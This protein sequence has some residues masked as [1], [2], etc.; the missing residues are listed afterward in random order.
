M[1]GLFGVIRPDG[2]LPSD[3]VI[4]DGLGAQLLHRGPN[5]SGF[6]DEKKALLGM[7]RLSI[8]DPLHGWQPF[9]TEDRSVGVLGN[10]EIYNAGELRA[11]LRARGHVLHTNSDIE[12]VP[13]LFE[14]FGSD[15]FGRLRG[16]FALV[17]VDKASRE[18]LLVRDRLGEKPLCY[19]QSGGAIYISSEQRALVR[20]GVTPLE[21][22]ADLV[23]DYLLYGYSPEP[24]SLIR[25]VRKVPAGHTLKISLMDGSIEESAYWTP[26][27]DVG[28]M[29]VSTD[30]LASAIESAVQASCTSDVPVGLALSG[31][32]D[33][34]L[35]ASLAVRD[36]TDLR[37][38]TVGYTQQGT[39]ESGLANEL[40]RHLG[41]P[42]YTTILRTEDVARDFA[43]ICGIRDEPIS[44]I[45]GPALAAIPRAAQQEGVT[46]LLTGLGG[47]ELFWGYDWIRQLA[48]WSSDQVQTLNAGGAKSVPQVAP[49]P[50]TMQGR[51][52]WLVNLAGVRRDREMAKF[53]GRPAGTQRFRMPFYE[54][55][56][57][58][59]PVARAVA[60]LNGV[61]VMAGS[62]L[63]G[64]WDSE[65]V[66][67]AYMVG[68]LETYLR[69]NGFVQI[70]RLAMNYSVESRTPLA[71]ANLVSLVLCGVSASSDFRLAPKARLRE[72]ATRYLPPSVT[73]RPKRGFTPPVRDWTRA[74]WEE[75]LD[76]LS[77][78]A[79]IELGGLNPSATR[80]WMRRPI[81]KTGRVN[82]IGMRLL[83]LELWLRSLS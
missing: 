56:P 23:P 30:D 83:T 18:V 13:H 50:R 62:Q 76:A 17:L 1:C 79:S 12:V 78:E 45:A 27:H 3:R 28:R 80:A 59:R 9:W 7:H 66:P 38:F 82:Q 5:G 36:R 31:G 42:C 51:A 54:F 39:D 34:S 46:V 16:M 53:A 77:G 8:M 58:Y 4:F 37:A 11:Q 73:N 22:D 65:W 32:L 47:D 2:I 41:I 67:A 55:Q 49:L 61:N 81:S 52:D 33:S 70:D 69:V 20:S 35:V 74:I 14:E 44:D 25:G 43:H 26:M 15:A 68:V 19:W 24:S 63:S 40:A 57:G 21:L 71:D 75:N 60:E 29:E 48:V 64:P 6:I 72:I 10:G